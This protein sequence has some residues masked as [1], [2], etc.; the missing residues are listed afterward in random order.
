[1]NT[2]TADGLLNHFKTPLK[3]HQVQQVVAAKLHELQWKRG[4]YGFSSLPS[5]LEVMSGGVIR[6]TSLGCGMS[7]RAIR[8]LLASLSDGG[9]EALQRKPSE[10]RKKRKAPAAKGQID[11]EGWL[12]AH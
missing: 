12:D 3:T 11:L 7:K 9:P 2:W 8:E 4:T 6:F 5:G 10:T 1:M